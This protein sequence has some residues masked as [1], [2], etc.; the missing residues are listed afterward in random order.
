MQELL[1]E[2]GYELSETK[3]ER[4]GSNGVW[5]RCC[6]PA[7]VWPAIV[8][9]F[10]QRQESVRYLFLFFFSF[11]FLGLLLSWR[12]P[13]MAGQFWGRGEG[14]AGGVFLLSLL[15]VA[16]FYFNFKN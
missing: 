16:F 9:T 11:S 12:V 13:A 10:L 15:G 8:D 4:S 3:G 7:T 14:A 5:I 6:A 1:I 2:P